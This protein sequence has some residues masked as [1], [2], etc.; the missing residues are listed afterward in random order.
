[1]SRTATTAR[2]PV[3]I[4][5]DGKTFV[6]DRREERMCVVL[7]G[8]NPDDDLLN[9]AAV[10]VASN[11]PYGT[12]GNRQTRGGW[13][14]NGCKPLLQVGRPA[15]DAAGRPCT[16]QFIRRGDL[17]RALAPRIEGE[18]PERFKDDEGKW[19]V[20]KCGT[21]RIVTGRPNTD[22]EDQIEQFH[23]DFREMRSPVTGQPV[24]ACREQLVLEAKRLL[25]ATAS[26]RPV[27]PPALFG[28]E[29]VWLT[30]FLHEIRIAKSGESSTDQAKR[31]A[32][33]AFVRWRKVGCWHLDGET[34][35]ADKEETHYKPRWYVDKA[36]AQQIVESIKLARL[37]KVHPSRNRLRPVEV[38]REYREQKVWAESLAL[39]AHRGMI[40]RRRN[41]L[42]RYYLRAELNRLIQRRDTPRGESPDGSRL[43]SLA[44]A[45]AL[46]GV[47]VRQLRRGVQKGQLPTHGRFAREGSLLVNEHLVSEADVEKFITPPDWN[48]KLGFAPAH[49][50]AAQM[51]LRTVDE[52]AALQ[53]TLRHGAKSGK[54]DCERSQTN[55][56]PIYYETAAAVAYL[57]SLKPKRRG[58]QV[59]NAERDAELAAL[60]F[61]EG[62]IATRSPVGC[63]DLY[64]ARHPGADE[65]IERN[66]RGRG[67]VSK[68]I[69]RFL[70][71][72]S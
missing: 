72:K 69:K 35:V 13:F 38:E 8:E 57:K 49:E 59:E 2:G 9:F 23:L 50:I 33:E 7:P 60:F 5:R 45:A 31:P 14:G 6:L 11:L 70:A 65:R 68:A 55:R 41:K 44:E 53:H 24:K 1:M 62:T 16:M 20:T 56:F 4:E 48:A 10:A 3:V 19:V 32:R 47:P 27:T 17:L 52:Y 22:I 30:A 66:R 26:P 18:T 71:R 40:R 21:A 43:R 51:N 12:V 63:I 54:V 29:T 64:N 34:L 37:G 61:T 58:R 42:G 46:C 15:T 67:L 39:W 36:Q 25:D 28:R